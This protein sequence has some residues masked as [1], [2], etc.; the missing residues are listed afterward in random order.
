MYGTK[1]KIL[2]E[3]YLAKKRFFLFEKLEEDAM[4]FIGINPSN[5]KN[6]HEYSI[7]NENGV[8]WGREE[9]KKEYSRFYK[10][11]NKLSLGMKW[12]HLDLFFSLETNSKKLKEMKGNKFLEEQYNISTE[13][14]KKIEPKIIIVGNAYASD[15]IKEKFDCNFINEIGTYV[16]KEFNNI[17]I[18]FSGMFS[19][20]HALDK[21]SI[22]RLIWHIGLVKE[23]LEI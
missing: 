3:G 15:L 14:I 22:E 11:F 4:L 2:L 17:P 8:Y 19:G 7:N 6:I 16:I 9:F 18:F 13:I 10:P 1:L 23:R 21:G 5:V 12:S 20:Q